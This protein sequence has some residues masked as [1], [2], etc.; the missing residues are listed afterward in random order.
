MN[1]CHYFETE[2]L[3]RVAKGSCWASEPGEV[4]LGP[5]THPAQREA[6]RL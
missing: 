1:Q 3:A 2:V 5:K 4:P 6:A